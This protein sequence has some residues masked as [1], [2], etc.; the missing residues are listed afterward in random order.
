[1][2]ITS[3]LPQDLS[4]PNRLIPTCQDQDN[5]EINQ[6]VSKTIKKKKKK[7]VFCY[8]FVQSIDSPHSSKLRLH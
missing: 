3:L 1:M 4:T 8:Q 7:Q 6:L 2:I 5:L